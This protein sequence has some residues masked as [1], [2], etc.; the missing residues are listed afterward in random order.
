MERERPDLVVL[1]VRL[2]DMDGLTVCRRARR[3][4]H[5]MPIL[6]LTALDRVGDRV[7]GL[8]AGADDYLAKPFAIEELLARLRALQRRAGGEQTTLAAGPVHLDL[9]SREVSVDGGAVELTAREFD[10]LAFLMHAPG[11]RVHPRAD[12]RGRV[13]LQLPGREQGDRLLRLGAAAQARH[14]SRELDHPHRARRRLHDPPVSVRLRLAAWFVLTMAVLV[15]ATSAITYAVVRSDLHDE[16]Q[17]SA[18]R[19]ARAAAQGPAGR[20]AARRDGRSGRP[21]LDHERRRAG[22]STRPPAQPGARSTASAASCGVRRRARP[23]PASPAPTV[24]RRSCSW[25]TTASARP[26]RPCFGR[27]SRSASASWSRPACWA[28]FWPG[29]RC[30]RST[31]CASR[32]TTSP[33]PRSTAASPRAGPTSSG[34]LAR[35]FN[36]LLERAE[37]AA[38]QQQRFVADASHELKT[39]VT[40]LQGHARIIS[41]SVDR[42]EWEQ[43]QRVGG[44]RRPRD[45]PAGGHRV[46]AAVAGRGR[47]PGRPRRAGAARQGRPPRRATRC[48]RSIPRRMLEAELEPAT[49]SG[50]A[51][52]PGRARA[53]A[54]RQRPQVQPARLAGGGRS[55]GCARTARA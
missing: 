42:E 27:S 53:R 35:A 28:R 40:A 18:R 44:G 46:G 4:G 22:W 25:P 41:R 50:D 17:H 20:A 47:Q 13:G 2:P 5:D 14:V 39:P 33:A 49:V 37:H 29:G 48:A 51:G 16:A 38:D 3:S 30:G 6:M 43:V 23:A 32:W 21:D 1:D 55:G 11:P 12:L 7:V 52:P 45:A 9:D 31:A 15:V 19:L 36:R 24:A 8:D 34:R 26:S 10:L 54:G